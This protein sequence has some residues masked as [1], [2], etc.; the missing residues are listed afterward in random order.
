MK[1]NTLHQ[2]KCERYGP[3]CIHKVSGCTDNRHGIYCVAPITMGH[4]PLESKGGYRI[5]L[6]FISVH[7][8]VKE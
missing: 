3:L 6:T 8:K 5:P 2:K 4:Q 7:G 1:T